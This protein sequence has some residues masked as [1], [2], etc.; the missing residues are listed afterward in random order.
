[1]RAVEAVAA[2]YERYRE[3][4]DARIAANRP[5]LDSILSAA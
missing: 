3:L 4:I 1:L 2:Y 5:D